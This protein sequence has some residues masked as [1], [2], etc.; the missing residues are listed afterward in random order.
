[1]QSACPLHCR[2]EE[3]VSWMATHLHGFIPFVV[4][5]TKD[6]TATHYTDVHKGNEAAAYLQFIVDY[7][8]CLPQVMAFIHAHRRDT[9]VAPDF[10]MVTAHLVIST[11]MSAMQLTLYTTASANLSAW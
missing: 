9:K 1:M 8:E 4:Y 6:S 3:D 7:Y 11:Y 10:D 5:N 2:Y